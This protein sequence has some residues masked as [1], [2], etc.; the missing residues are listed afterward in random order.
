MTCFPLNEISYIGKLCL[1]AYFYEQSFT[2]T[3]GTQILCSLM[4]CVYC[5]FLTTAEFSSWD[6][7]YRACK[8]TDISG[9]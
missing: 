2:G 6:R 5:C 8:A 1:A 3:Q 9:T 7:D 4:Y